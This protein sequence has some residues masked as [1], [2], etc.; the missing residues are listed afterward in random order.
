MSAF[1]PNNSWRLVSTAIYSKPLDARI[2]G[3]VELDVTDLEDWV[4]K[5]RE[6]GL[7]I[8]LMYPLIL[9]TARALKHEVPAINCYVKR[10]HIV[11]RSSV[12]IMVSVLMDRGQQMGSLRLKDADQ[13]TLPQMAAWMKENLQKHREQDVEGAARLKNSLARISWPFRGMLIWIWRK[14]VVEWGFRIP[15]THMGPDAFG[16]MIFS[17][18]GSIGLDIGYPALLPVSNVALV[19]NMGSINTK[20]VV[21]DGQIVPR[22][23]L[24]LSATMD[25][26]VVDA[27]QGGKLFRYLKRGI[28]HPDRLM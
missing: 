25:H 20:P 18:I 5:R 6:D 9:L 7:K 13:M 8:T 14:L 2:S 10:G 15:F 3:S 22:R 11:H 16:S 1:T 28:R 21:I 17:N 4:L 23:I 26:R 19:L 12:D 24:N 27:Q